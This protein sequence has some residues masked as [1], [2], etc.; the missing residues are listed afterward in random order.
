MAVAQVATASAD[1][2][3]KST[4]SSDADS[5][6]TREK[7]SRRFDFIMSGIGYAVGVGNIWRFPYLCMR[8]GG[9]AFLIPYFFFLFTCAIP[10][11]F[12]ELAI[13]QYSASSPMTA[14]RICPLFK[15]LGYAMILVSGILCIYYNVI[16][17]WVLFY[18]AMSF[19]TEVPWGGCGNWWNT[20]CCLAAGESRNATLLGPSGT[21]STGNMLNYLPFSQSNTSSGQG[22]VMVTNVTVDLASNISYIEDSIFCNKSTSPTEEYWQSAVLGMSSGIDNLGTVKWELLICLILAWAL[23]FV[24]LCKGVKSS[25]LIVYVTATTPYIFLTILLIRGATLEGSLEGVKY[26]LTPDFSKLAE[27]RV[28]CEACLQVFYSLGPAWGG[29]ITMASYNEFNNNIMRDSLLIPMINCGTSFYGGFVIFSVM[30]Y[31]AK[32]AGLRVDE[33]VKQGPGLAFVVYPEAIAQ[34]PISPLWAILFFLMLLT[35]GLDSQFVTL[36][37]LTS[38]F[39]DEFPRILRKRRTLFTLAVCVVEFLLGLACIT[40]GGIYVFQFMDWYCAAVAVVIIALLECLIVAYVY[41]A[42]RLSDDVASMVG[43]KP[44]ILWRIC[45]RFVTPGLLMMILG[46]S[47]FSYKPPSYGD[48]RFPDWIEPL[49]W[50]IATIPLIP[51]PVVMV[52]RIAFAAQGNIW[53]RIRFLLKPS[54]DWGPSPSEKPASRKI[55]TNGVT[56]A[57]D[58]ANGDTPKDMQE[59]NHQV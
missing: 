7:W 45:W 50:F 19:G 54:A 29:L 33:V 36:E 43:R 3:N 41:G 53:Q 35:L 39:I 56:V 14:W 57:Y 21:N 42:D 48:Y 55:E 59:E 37:T 9:G 34:L 44:F 6:P 23:T 27:F 26:Y 24:C 20:E 8:N 30:G 10:L 12:M 31:M 47:L 13:G 1:F 28:W 11:Y 52:W 51:I 58:L 49:G 4:T 25:G 2:E 17:T 22:L 18:L 16:L 15:G 40:N 38:S 32:V 5:V 46:F